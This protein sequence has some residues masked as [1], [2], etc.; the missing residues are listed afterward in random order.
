MPAGEIQS[1]YREGDEDT[2]AFLS[3]IFSWTT[4]NW[5]NRYEILDLHTGEP[6]GAVSDE[7][8]AGPDSIRRG[9][10]EPDFYT[11][12]S[13]PYSFGHRL[14]GYKPVPRNPRQARHFGITLP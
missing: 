11:I 14:V 2:K 12:A 5:T 6:L 8:W 7:I 9:R 3:K 1:C 4:R 13:F 10:E